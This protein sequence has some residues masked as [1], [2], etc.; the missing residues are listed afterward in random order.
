[1]SSREKLHA[2][3]RSEEKGSRLSVL[4]DSPRRIEQCNRG[5]AYNVPATGTL[6]G[7]NS[8]VFATYGY[9]TNRNPGARHGPP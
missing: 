3:S 7:V 8:S 4:T 1:L 2:I 5:M 6:D 9:R